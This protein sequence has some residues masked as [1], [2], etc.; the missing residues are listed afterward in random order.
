MGLSLQ[1]A[2]TRRRSRR[3]IILGA[4]VCSDNHAETTTS[5]QQILLSVHVLVFKRVGRLDVVFFSCF[6]HHG[7]VLG[8][9]KTA[10]ASFGCFCWWTVKIVW[11]TF[12]NTIKCCCKNAFFLP[13]I[14]FYC[15]AKNFLKRKWKV[16][17]RGR[18][19]ERK[20]KGKKGEGKGGKGNWKWSFLSLRPFVC[21]LKS[22]SSHLSLQK[23]FVSEKLRQKRPSGSSSGIYFRQT[24]GRSFCLWSFGSLAY[25]L[26][27]HSWLIRIPHL[28]FWGKFSQEFNLVKKL[29][30]RK[31]R[32]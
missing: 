23:I 32:N 3:L 2:L 1:T 20:G 6:V 7:L 10:H 25:R 12:I 11:Q 21:A 26:S 31:R 28:S 22:H 17:G 29:L 15:T 18:G 8:K 27:S 5:L 30:W 19:R 13:V 14:T 16:E 24:S 9:V 4:L